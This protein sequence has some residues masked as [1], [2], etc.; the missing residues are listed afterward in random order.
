M[1]KLHEVIR[2]CRKYRGLTIRAAADKA[3]MH[4]VAWSAIENGRNKN[5]SLATLKKIAGALG[6]S[7]G[8]LFS[9]E[10]DE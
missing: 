10:E 3:G 9:A 5:P 6:V 4:R 2:I 7:V 1:K 8:D